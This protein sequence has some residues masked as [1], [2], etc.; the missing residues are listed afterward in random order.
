[1]QPKRTK[2]DTNPLDENVAHRADESFGRNGSSAPTEDISG[3]T[4]PINPDPSVTSRIPLETSRTAGE[5]EAPT[6][7]IDSDKVTSYPSVFVPPRTAT[8]Y[9]PPRVAPA[10]IYQPPPGP[11]PNIYQPPGVPLPIKPGSK[12]VEGL[13]IP[14]RWALIIPYIPAWL[15]LIAALVELLIVPRTETRTRFH[16]SQ[17]LVLQLGMTAISMLLTM[18]SF[19]GRWTGAP[20]FSIASSVFLIVAMVKVWKGKP[21][22]ISVLE[23][24][25]RWIEEKIKTK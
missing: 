6:R 18:L 3:P 10:N 17:A 8:T 12:Q 19:S 22:V 4:R 11:A 13:G 16:A 9:Q 15:G 23:A 25:R 2:Y 1:M 24:P 7:R 21:F 14:E 20:L 5:S